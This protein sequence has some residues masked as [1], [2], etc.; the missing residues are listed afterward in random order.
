MATGN[1][2]YESQN[3]FCHAPAEG[4]SVAA[5]PLVPCPPP[6]I[7][8]AM[9]STRSFSTLPLI[10]TFCAL[11]LAGAMVIPATA[12]PE[13]PAQPGQPPGGAR[14]GAPGAGQRGAGQRGG[15]RGAAAPIV[16]GPAAPVPPE[17]AI[18]RPTAAE[19]AQADT[20]LKKLAATDSTAQALLVKYPGLIAV[21]PPRPNFAATYT[22][23]QQRNGRH[24]GFVARA[25]QGD[26]DVLFHGDSITDNWATTGK[27]V[28]DK[29]FGGMKVA[30]FAIGGDRTE[31]LLWGLKNG[32]GQGFSP[33]AIMLMVGTNNTG[34][35]NTTV[36]QAGTGPEIAEGVG[37]VVMELRKDF[38][39]AKILLLAIFPRGADPTDAY[40]QKNETANKLLA[41]L[42]DGRNV[43]FMDIGAK[44]LTPEG[45]LN[46][47]IMADLLHPTEKGY[48]IWAEAVKDKLAELMK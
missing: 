38:P 14:G 42:H 6:Q 31:G 11:A 15:A 7:R 8:P 43:F 33:K 22:L 48:E 46:R 29:Y 36:Y 23:T 12:Q 20:A 1:S 30:N 2:T 4:R 17:V 25:Q 5:L 45:I 39:T 24:E 37:A 10:R 44:F 27:A 19:L 3:W 18:P 9:K 16:I 26:I 47:D 34:T 21:Q 41:K 32:E 40:R 35:G 13:P 28:F